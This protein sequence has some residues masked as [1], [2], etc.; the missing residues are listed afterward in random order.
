[1]NG[2]GR[3]MT[4]YQRPFLEVGSEQRARPHTVP[5][6]PSGLSSTNEDKHRCFD[7][8]KVYDLWLVVLFDE[9]FQSK[10]WTRT[11]RQC[12]EP[13][14]RVLYKRVQKMHLAWKTWLDLHLEVMDDLDGQN[15]ASSACCLALFL[16][17][18]L[19]VGFFSFCLSFPLAFQLALCLFIDPLAVHLHVTRKRAVRTS[20]V[21]MTRWSNKQAAVCTVAKRNR[22]SH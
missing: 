9:T 1:M 7:E 20:R 14:R 16:A 15:K 22:L 12:H 19:F 11:F 3:W 2:I 4:W 13:E 18:L 6:W 8:A 21:L 10:C 5:D 17:T